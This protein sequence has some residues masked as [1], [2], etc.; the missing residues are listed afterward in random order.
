M[1]RCST[2][3]AVLLL[4]PT[5][6]AAS[7]R[8]CDDLPVRVSLS[9]SDPTLLRDEPRAILS[10]RAVAVSAVRVELRRGTR[11][12]ASGFLS[13]RLARGRTAVALTL[14]AGRQVGAG[15]YRLIAIG[16]RAGCAG[17]ASAA[18]DWRFGTPSLPVRAAPIS[19]FVRDNEGSLRLILR[20]VGHRRV[21][22]VR[23][24]LLDAAGA[25]VAQSPRRASFRGEKVV[26]LPVAGTLPP[27]SY[28]LR[29]SGKSDG[30][31]ETELSEQP[32][33]LAAGGNGNGG[34]NGGGGP[35]PDPTQPSPVGL[36]EQ[37]AVVDWSGG[38][39]RGRDVAGFVAPGVGYG[40]L[41]CRPDAQWIRFYPTDLQ[42]EV[43]MMTWT[44]KDWAENQ[45]KAVREAQYGPF[46]GPDFREGLN[47]FGPPEKRSTGEFS[48]IVSDRGPFGSLGGAS[49]AAPT[50]FRLTWEWDLTDSRTSRCHVE[51][52]F[53]TENAAGTQAPLAR[54][55]SLVWRGDANAA[56]HDSAS[57]GVPG[58]GTV[59]LTCQ[60]G[61]RGARTLTVDTA[62]GADVTTREGSDDVARGQ[63]F[64]PIV[65]QLPN[66]GMLA[67]RFSNGA[68]LLASSRW[69]VNDP[70]ATQNACFVAAQA[71]VP[72]S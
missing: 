1:R 45:E 68:T 6:G 15:R 47:K 55:T 25:T 10:P 20:S 58:L 52:T 5:L 59:S 16:R 3:L 33:T 32:L 48:G 34:G 42:R 72:V 41:V 64:G 26:D 70:D 4:A 50:T 14:A 44:Y 37:R 60:A 53:L 54:S 61:V 23:V 66:N 7:A 38:E 63:A 19:T 71:V 39:S 51:A 40:E 46:T 43:A 29:V 36:V 17:R 28:T 24:R 35:A 8:A 21:R 49:L 18:R 30:A 62:L 69:K 22:G 65:A 9:S 57:V 67:I 11:L 31:A 27:G 13:G 12:Y 56:G 2:L